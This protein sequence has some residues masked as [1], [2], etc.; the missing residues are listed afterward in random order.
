VKEFKAL[1]MVRHPR[2]VV[3]STVRDQ[4]PALVPHLRD[5]ESVVVSS[6]DDRSDGSVQLV[7][8]W[9]ARA[10]IPPLLKT[11][12]KPE[13]LA[14]TDLAQWMPATWQCQWEIRPHFMTENVRCVGT[15]SYEEAMAGRGTRVIFN[16]RL[17]IAPGRMP[18]VTTLI[19]GPTIRGVEAFVTALVP[20]NFQK[21]AKAVDEHLQSASA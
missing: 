20:K 5:V 2:G 1:A 15:T 4:M 16:G 9:R 6:R 8:E 11:V 10:Q 14:W 7:N 21:L 18:G 3:W 17:D 13:M 19:G 12:I